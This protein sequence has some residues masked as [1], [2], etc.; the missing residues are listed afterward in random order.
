MG[1][2]I[3]TVLAWVELGQYR[4]RRRQ[5][6]TVAPQIEES[7][8]GSTVHP[9]RSSRGWHALIAAGSVGAIAA[10]AVQTWYTP[11][12]AIAGGDLAPPNG[13]AWLGHLFSSWTW[14]GS[15]FGHPGGFQTQ[16]LWAGLLWLVHDVGGSSILAQRIWY[17]VLFSAAA[18]SALWLLRLLRASWPAAIVGALLYLFNT[19]VVS[20][21]G[22]NPVFLGALVL[23]VMVPAIVLSVTFGK[24]RHRSGAM[25]LV[26]AVPMIGYVYQNP[27]L[28]LAVAAAGLAA[29]VVSSIWFGRPGFR[30]ALAFVGL[31]V[32]LA[33]LASLYWLV[34]S[35]E[36]LHFEA[37]GQ[38][39]TL[40]NWTWTEKRA[41]L[42]NAFWLNTSWA[43]PFK[44]YVP[45][46]GNY[47]TFPLSVLRYAF[48]LI[49][50]AALAL[51][52]GPSSKSIRDLTLAA[53]GA[54]GS[55]LV[56][57]LST[58]TRLPGSLLF[59]LVYR[60]PYGWL[61]QGPGRF[62]LLA[63]VGYAVMAVVTVDAWISHIEL[64]VGPVR[65]LSSGDR[66]AMKAGF[67]VAVV[68]IAGLVPGYPLAF[69]AVVPRPRLSGR[70]SMHVRVPSYWSAMASY[71]NGPRSAPGNL[72]VLPPDPFYQVQYRWGYYGNDAFITDMVRRNVLDPSGQGYGP[73]RAT[74]LAAVNQVTTS[75]LAGHYGT[76]NR[77]IRSMGTPDVLI[78]GDVAGR[79][80]ETP[81]AIAAALRADPSLAL[82]HRSG[83]LSL[84]RLR[85]NSGT[86]AG[87][88][89]GEP[90][91]TAQAA[92]PNLLA[93]STLPAG[94][95]IVHHAPIPGVPAV[96]QVP[97]EVSWGLR[98][99][100]LH[101]V[102]ALPPGRSYE[103]T[104]LGKGG[105]HSGTIALP[106]GASRLVGGVQLTTRATSTATLASLSA[107]VS[108][109]ELANGTFA[110]G[111]WGGVGNCNAIPGTH[112]AQ[113]ARLGP[114]PPSVPGKA[115]VLSARAEIACES[116]P[117]AWHGGPVLLTLSAR[118]VSGSGPALCLWEIG[119]DHCA[120]LPPLDAST[121]WR[122]Y[123][124]I[125][126]PPPGT[127]G[128]A[129]FLY[130]NGNGGAVPSA[131]AY[132]AVSIRS[133]PMLSSLD[134]FATDTGGNHH[135][136][137][138]TTADSTFSPLWTVSG[139]ADHVLVDGMLNGWLS[140]SG[141][142]LVPH[143]TTSAVIRA[144]FLVSLAA[145]GCTVLL[146]TGVMVSNLWVRG[147]RR[148]RSHE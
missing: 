101:T 102:V 91:V 24:W 133:L 123:Q 107:P 21:V 89:T 84:Y 112:P 48:P 125:V 43:W 77:I 51:R 129:L 2:A 29:L 59:D 53:S 63:G 17:T 104:Q 122:T 1:L 121:R 136:L 50:F 103:V 25:A 15:D 38:L 87:V 31:A 126:A 117:V 37:I 52:Y 116:Q 13:T 14:S 7:P 46:S 41:T 96:V 138:L 64:V 16:L 85:S 45:Y 119:P 82:V 18:L 32:P 11:G 120:S 147:V 124:Q 118:E 23:V 86:L 115:L 108:R 62:L 5:V 67:A 8:S 66:M 105:K 106:L 74:L 72:L 142:P 56:I 28:V 114:A 3:G 90:Y 109:N 71:L 130:A 47:A 27:P 128:L 60:L 55:L 113:A 88:R 69:G 81:Q 100:E 6:G 20:S 22:V 12:T 75:L 70:P 131:A 49:A 65:G 94:M 92:A 9:G 61:L 76:A 26:A 68:V 140:G 98:G 42:P 143:N 35:F 33:A 97:S 36:Q 78:R 132:A 141:Q 110:A 73:A 80:P 139:T 148:M 93:L 79:S 58:G 144:G 99:R 44:Q 30:R 134:I 137:V 95:A 111:S 10:G 19:F 34:P 57:F 145:I 4:R 146:A 135:P 83:P 127:Q 39:S 54:T 40:S